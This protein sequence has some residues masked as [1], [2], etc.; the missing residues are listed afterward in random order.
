MNRDWQFCAEVLAKGSRSFSWATYLLPAALR[1]RVVPV[2]AFCRLADDAADDHRQ[3]YS[4]AFWQERVEK[5]FLQKPYANPVDRALSD[6]IAGQDVPKELFYYLLEGF[7]WDRE[8]RVYRDIES[9][10]A[11]ATRVAGVV[12]MMLLYLVRIRDRDILARAGEMGIAM[13]LSNIARDVA[14]D[15]RMGRLYLP[16]E[17]LQAEGLSCENVLG[18]VQYSV[19]LEKVLLRLLAYSDQLYQRAS[20]GIVMLP[21]PLRW[22]FLSAA[23][24]YADLNRVVRRQWR[25]RQLH[26]AVVGSFRKCTLLLQAWWQT[27]S[28]YF[29]N[30]GS[31]L[32]PLPAIADVLTVLPSCDA[33]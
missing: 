2:Y 32:A 30:E 14:E 5:A 26:R 4:V 1:M 13:Q 9:L 7:A 23:W 17:W 29:S 6:A 21:R 24:I 33:L 12:G 15:A 16:E 11:Y 10:L 18:N 20:S 22:G 3:S 25:K 27:R 28:S 19:A 8:Q 31:G